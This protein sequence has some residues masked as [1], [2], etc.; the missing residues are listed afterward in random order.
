[1]I[2]TTYTG[3][4]VDIKNFTVDD[5]IVED[6]AHSLAHLCR[7]G[8]HTRSFYSVA[9]HSVRVAYHVPREL[10]LEGLLHDATEAYVV[11]LPRP[12]KRLLPDYMAME[13]VIWSIIT[14][15]FQ[16]PWGKVSAAVKEAD[17]AVLVAEWLELMSAPLPP[18]LA[19]VSPAEPAIAHLSPI[20]AKKLFLQ[21]FEVAI[22]C[23]IP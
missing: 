23:H 4:R 11:D 18:E 15:R 9:Q 1:M 16:M 14:Q 3:R 20:A 6:I 7:F 8:G 10:M 17:E 19:S 12:I 2:S 5:I 21:V 13:D 22:S